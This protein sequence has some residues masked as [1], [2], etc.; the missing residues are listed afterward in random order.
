MVASKRKE[1]KTYHSDNSVFEKKVKPKLS[2]VLGSDYK[3]QDE[4]EKVSKETIGVQCSLPIKEDITLSTSMSPDD[5]EKYC[6]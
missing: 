4:H 6:K 2:E 3:F 5:I 1:V